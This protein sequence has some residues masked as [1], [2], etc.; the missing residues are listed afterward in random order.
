MLHKIQIIAVLIA[1]LMVIAPAQ[2]YFKDL[3]VGARPLGMGGAY[4]ATGGDVTYGYWNPAGLSQIN[5]PE[6]AAMHSERF[7]GVVNYDYLA[8][9]LPFR[10]KETFAL[11]AIRLGVDDI[12]IS[13]IP[14]PDLQTDIQYTDEEGNLRVNRPYVDRYVS[15]AEYAFYLSYAKQHSRT[16]SFGANAKFVHKGVCVKQSDSTVNQIIIQLLSHIG[17]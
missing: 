5:Y 8:F 6:L 12:P 16:F 17:R 13:A 7:A 1:L 3:G 14:R 4:V 10:Q 9:S 2:A 11:S 15:D